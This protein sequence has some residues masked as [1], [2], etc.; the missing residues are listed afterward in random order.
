MGGAMEYLGMARYSHF[1]ILYWNAAVR[2]GVFLIVVFLL[3]S[4]RS[5]GYELA[6]RVEERT[7][8]LAMEIEERKRTEAEREVVIAELRDALSNVKHLHG[9]LPIC[10]SCKRIRDDHGY[11]NDV[12]EYIRKHTEADFT[13]GICPDCMNK[14]YPGMGVP[15]PT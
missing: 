9:L 3:S 1:I 10:A 14:L 11:W 7:A 5:W 12:E 6:R 2:L 15:S 8:L 13:H 4:V